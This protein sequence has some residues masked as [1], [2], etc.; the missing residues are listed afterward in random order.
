MSII[1]L[2]ACQSLIA[3]ND[4]LVLKN[5]DIIVGEIKTLK[6]GVLTIETDYSDKDFVIEWTGISE[7]FSKTRF[8][9]TL[10]DGT[11]LTG[12]IITDSSGKKLKIVE[13]D[14]SQMMTT[15]EDLVFLKGLKSDFWSRT[16]ANIDLGIN[17]I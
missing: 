15:L 4:S 6:K 13:D 1:V 10:K 17:S 8:L 11:R 2:L 9:L 7:I 5:K 12:H 16:K 3:Q 14:D